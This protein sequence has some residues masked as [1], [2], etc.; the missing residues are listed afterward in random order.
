MTSYCL[1]INCETN[2]VGWMRMDIGLQNTRLTKCNHRAAW[3][4]IVAH[5]LRSQCVGIRRTASGDRC[6]CLHHAI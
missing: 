4:T 3:K 1:A 6:C 2:S 5:S